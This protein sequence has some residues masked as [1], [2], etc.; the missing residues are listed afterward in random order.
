LDH[1]AWYQITPSQSWIEGLNFSLVNLQGD[2]DNDL[3]VSLDDLVALASEWLAV[4][5]LGRVDLDGNEIIDLKDF[6]VLA[7]N[8]LKA[9][10]PNP[11][12][13]LAVVDDVNNPV[14]V[15]GGEPTLPTEGV[16][17]CEVRKKDALSDYKMWYSGARSDGRRIYLATSPDGITWTKQG[18]VLDG[19]ASGGLA[20]MPSVLWDADAGLWKMWYT[21]NASGSQ[22]IL[23]A[24]SVDGST[25]TNYGKVFG[26]SEN[27][28]DWDASSVRSPAVLFDQDDNLYKMWYWGNNNGG[29]P[30]VYGDRGTGFA[31]SPDGVN[32]T[33]QGQVS[34]E[35]RL[36]NG[37]V[38]KINGVFYMFSNF[39]PHIGMSISLDGLTW[40]DYTPNPLIYAGRQSQSWKPSYIDA[41]SMV[42][43]ST[44]GQ[45]KIYYYGAD[46]SLPFE[47]TSIGF[48]TTP[49]K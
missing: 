37:D 27:A 23:Y 22:S 2:V 41:A 16:L 46:S 10:L 17:H 43:D 4:G 47:G 9:A 45:M 30:Q 36:S 28:A 7:E 3:E 31:T 44:V 20:H 26:P 14:L 11:W 8:Y 1:D 25:W 38:L 42:Y 24:T 6:S 32:W 29:D 35:S 48:A 40:H 13:S 12:L 5:S 33:R 15:A 19:S 34:D 21:G 49:F 18:V 39:G